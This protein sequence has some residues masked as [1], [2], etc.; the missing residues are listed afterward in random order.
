MDLAR[1]K[2]NRL[3]R[4]GRSSGS[5]AAAA[6]KA[7]AMKLLTGEDAVRV[8]INAPAGIALTFDIEEV[9]GDEE[10]ARAAVRKDSGDDPDVTNGVLVIAEARRLR[11]YVSTASIINKKYLN[12]APDSDFCIPTLT[13]D[14]GQGIGRVTKPGL[15][16]P[17]GAAAINSV[18]RRMIERE[19]SEVCVSAG[20]GGGISVV[21]SIPE[22]EK[23]AK[24]TLNP[25]LGIVGGLSVLGTSGIVE[26]MS[27]G[28]LV[29]T[30]RLEIKMLAAA[31]HREILLTIGNY[32]EAFVKDTLR[33]GPASRVKCSNFLGD[34]I[35]AAVENGFRKI[36]IVGHIGKLAKLGIGMTNTHSSN[37]D[38]RIETL[39]ACALMAGADV[40]ILNA[41]AVCATVNA[42][43]DV[44]RERGK[45]KATAARLSERI[46]GTLASKVPDSVDIGFLCFSGDEILAQ[47]DNVKELAAVFEA[48]A[49]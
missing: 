38:G 26:P 11:T 3:L 4:C 29:D 40:D 12:N 39:I 32:G 23:L 21:I 31:G 25:Q 6:A 45:L 7:A 43:I 46:S 28:A 22:G 13:I 17:V 35:D 5:C 49:T 2:N 36:L 47:S 42:A 48:A 44:L 34:A 9:S 24:R 27:V 10:A 15:D 37:G 33:I 8:T 16:Q 18:P 30:L 1:Y 19:V 14:G 41:I 20:Y